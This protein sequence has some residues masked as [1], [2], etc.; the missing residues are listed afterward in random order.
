VHRLLAVPLL[1]V[2]AVPAAAQETGEVAAKPAKKPRPNVY[3]EKA[4]GK[5]LVAAACAKAAKENKRVLVQWGGNWCGWCHILHDVFKKEPEVAKLIRDEYELVLVDAEQFKKDEGHWKKLGVD[6]KGQGLPY[7]TV[8]DASGKLVANQPTEPLETPKEKAKTKG[9]EKP[10]VVEFLKKHSAPP[11]IASEA[12]AAAVAKAKGENKLVFLHFGAP[13]CGWCRHL[14]NW[15]AQPDVAALL[16]KDFVDLKIDTDRMTGGKD[17][18]AA[19]CK[20]EGG[21]PWF[22]FLDADGNSMADS[23]AGRKNIGF[24]STDEE[25]TRFAALLT[26]VKRKLAAEDVSAIS[27]SLK[28]WREKTQQRSGAAPVKS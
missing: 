5:A 26:K 20:E 13:W 25:I 11:R 27:E 12:L 6:L 19:H 15:A 3:D 2:L 28:R 7:L 14:E 22:A 8:V 21:I 23:G 9:Y 10:K 1:C 18:L 17:L 4:D 16:A 24:P